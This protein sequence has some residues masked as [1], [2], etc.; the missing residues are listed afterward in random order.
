M[1]D[2]KDGQRLSE[3][4]ASGNPI[5]S[6]PRHRSSFPRCTARRH[7]SFPRLQGCP[8][9]HDVFDQGDVEEIIRRAHSS[10]VATSPGVTLMS[11]LSVM[12]ATVGCLLSAHHLCLP[13]LSGPENTLI[14][15]VRLRSCW[16]LGVGKVL[17]VG[18]R[19]E[20]PRRTI[21]KDVGQILGQIFVDL[22]IRLDAGG[23]VGFLS[24]SDEC[25]LNPGV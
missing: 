16:S 1:R 9:S 25:C 13:D 17:D 6:Q 19:D 20:S 18:I 2:R 21:Q 14:K 23:W 24:P 3:I 11:E 15:S 7:G 10:I 12:I 4:R 8:A 22:L 5:R